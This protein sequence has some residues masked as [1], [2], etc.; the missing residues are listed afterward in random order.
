MRQDIMTTLPALLAEEL[1]ADWSRVTVEIS[2]VAE[3]YR[4]PRI[5][6]MFTGN[7]ESTT[8]FFDLLLR[9]GASAREMLI[10]AA[11]KRWQ[12]EPRECHA[13]GGRILHRPSA[14][15]VAFG[16]LVE[17]AARETPPEGPPLKAPR[18]W[19]L[20]GRSLPRVE[21]PGKVNGTAIFGLDFRVPG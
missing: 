5:N 21:L 8:G 1:G 4:N 9:M 11:A 19:T 15:A 20:L 18:D 2:P 14:R 13:A 12:V 17:A 16:D 6:W 7:S 3:V 10:A